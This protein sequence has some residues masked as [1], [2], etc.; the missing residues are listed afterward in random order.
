MGPLDGFGYFHTL[1]G[2]GRISSASLPSYQP[3]GM[4]GRLNSSAALSL[5]G[6][7][8]SVIQPGHCQTSNNP[9]NGSGKIQPA[10]VQA[11]QR[12]WRI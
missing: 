2:P 10:V 5:H 8:S 3:G 12:L 4:F 6:I 9:I 7:S 11:H 1:T